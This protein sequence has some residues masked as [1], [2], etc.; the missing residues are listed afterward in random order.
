MRLR[1]TKTKQ[2]KKLENWSEVC[3]ITHATHYKDNRNSGRRMIIVYGCNLRWFQEKNKL[4]KIIRCILPERR[5]VGVP[6]SVTGQSQ[7]SCCSFLYRGSHRSSY[8]LSQQVRW[9]LN[10]R[11]PSKLWPEFSHLK[12]FSVASFHLHCSIVSHV[13]LSFLPVF[14][15]EILAF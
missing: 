13:L 2:K 9:P 15:E 14:E 10:S 11:R 6:G 5:V 8:L 7:K 1:I 12:Q 4:L 3:I